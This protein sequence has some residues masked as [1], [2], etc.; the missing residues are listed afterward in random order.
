[1]ACDVNIPVLDSI[2]P[3]AEFR[4]ADS[5]LPPSQQL[6]LLARYGMASASL[7]SADSSQE[8]IPSTPYLWAELRHAAR[9][10]G[11]IHLDDLLLRR[12]RV[13][14]LAPGGGIDL[15]PRI[16][17]IVQPELGWDDSCW[18]KEARNYAE[19]WKRAYRLN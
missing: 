17:S 16:R 14:L 12:V 11:V 18:E 13:G 5:S 15:L 6:R 19:L 2:P 8:F 10:E 9:A 4:F 7:L 3:E 1:V